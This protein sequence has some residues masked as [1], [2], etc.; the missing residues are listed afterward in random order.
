MARGTATSLSARPPSPRLSIVSSPPVMTRS[1]SEAP[2]PTA[3]TIGSASVSETL[4]SVSSL[5]QVIPSPIRFNKRR[6]TGKRLP[7]APVFIGR[8]KAPAQFPFPS[9]SLVSSDEEDNDD[10][11][12]LFSW[13]SNQEH[14][15]I[16]KKKSNLPRAKHIKFSSIGSNSD[17]NPDR[18]CF[19]DDYEDDNFNAFRRCGIEDPLIGFSSSSSDT[20]T[21]PL[22]SPIVVRAEEPTPRVWHFDD[23]FPSIA[24]SES[25]AC[26]GGG[27]NSNG[28]R[29]R[30]KSFGTKNQYSGRRPPSSIRRHGWNDSDEG[31]DDFSR[32]RIK[33][34][35]A[36]DSRRLERLSFA[37]SIKRSFGFSKVYKREDRTPDLR[38]SMGCTGLFAARSKRRE[39]ISTAPKRNLRRFQQNK[40]DNSDITESRMSIRADERSAWDAKTA[41][42]LLLNSVLAYDDFMHSPSKPSAAA[43]VL[44]RFRRT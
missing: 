41:E 16:E 11:D 34:S 12:E 38:E 19:L 33:R 10:S 4:S 18:H 14:N 37:D 39:T 43:R 32:D 35:S 2:S 6:P 9:I 30:T 27:P 20:P 44:A 24:A 29:S 36:T 1:I 5:P 13:Q 40:T 42:E 22:P 17:S 23:D 25:T 7:Q 31:S 3:F 26:G 28:I 15:K 8:P 21:A